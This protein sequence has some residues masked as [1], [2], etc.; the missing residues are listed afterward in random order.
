MVVTTLKGD[1]S[2]FY[3]ALKFRFIFWLSGGVGFTDCVR[4]GAL[5]LGQRVCIHM[6]AHFVHQGKRI[7]RADARMLVH[8]VFPSSQ[9]HWVLHSLAN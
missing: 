8:K 3:D 1:I 4:Q 2:N 7:M 6:I 9:R 5:E